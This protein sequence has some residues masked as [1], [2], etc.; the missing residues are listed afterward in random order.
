MR[1]LPLRLQAACASAMELAERLSGHA[2]VVEV[3]YPG[4]PGHPGHDVARRQMRGGFGGMLSIR[5]HGGEAAAVS[6]A[7]RVDCG[8]AR[9]RSAASRA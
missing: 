7:A 2:A 9:R 6:T 8:S 3:L 5:V 4:L 1:T